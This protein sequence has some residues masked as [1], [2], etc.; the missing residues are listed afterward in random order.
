MPALPVVLLTTFV[1]VVSTHVAEAS[2]TSSKKKA[3]AKADI[4][5]VA[6]L[7]RGSKNLYAC[8]IIAVVGEYEFRVIRVEAGKLDEERIVVEA[9]CPEMSME[10]YHLS[11]LELSSKRLYPYKPQW[12]LEEPPAKRLYLQKQDPFSFDYTT[13]VGE[14]LTSLRTQFTAT[15]ESKDGWVSFGPGLQVHPKDGRVSKLRL[16]CPRGF[17]RS[18]SWLGLPEVEWQTFRRQGGYSEGVF[19]APNDI[20]GEAVLRCI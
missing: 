9:L 17:P 19:K 14:N 15:S 16:V 1:W 4:V 5:V 18:F 7:I 3:A 13:I 10:A 20:V 12:P 2:P 11:R 6:E 8:G